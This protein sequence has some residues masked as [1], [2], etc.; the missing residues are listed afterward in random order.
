MAKKL[1]RKL[2]PKKTVI[3]VVGSYRKVVS[4][5][6]G[7]LEAARRFAARSVN[8][9]MT[10][11]YREIGRRIVEYEQAGAARAEYGAA[12]IERLSTDLTAKFGR[13]FSS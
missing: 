1:A 5:I 3:S 13:V 7:V 9:V 12:L 11:T 2:P 4:G 6:V 10:T 8:V